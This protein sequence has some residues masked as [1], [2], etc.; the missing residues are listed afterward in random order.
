MILIFGKEKP[1]TVCREIRQTVRDILRDIFAMM[2][3]IFVF[4][5]A[6]L[7]ED[8]I[9][10]PASGLNVK[11]CL[12]PGAVRVFFQNRL[13]IIPDKL[14][15]LLCAAPGIVFR[16]KDVFDILTPETEKVVR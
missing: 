9:N 3:A 1:R 14:R 13:Y 2:S 4:T 5:F 16:H 8:H 15:Y 7:S 10:S 12:F 6:A 11:L